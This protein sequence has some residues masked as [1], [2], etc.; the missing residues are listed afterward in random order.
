[1]PKLASLKKAIDKA[2]KIK[3]GQLDRPGVAP[4]AAAAVGGALLLESD[5][6]NGGP[7]TELLKKASKVAKRVVVPLT[8]GTV[9]GLASRSEE[10]RASPFT[11]TTQQRLLTPPPQ[12]IVAD[13]FPQLERLGGF[14]EDINT[15]F[16][17]PL[18]GLGQFI[19]KLGEP[20][21]TEQ[22][23]NGAINA[24]PL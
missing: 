22:R 9:A 12:T 16:G 3:R 4:L 14:I 24:S 21:S 17:Q 19:R 13:E 23:I 10:G 1:M 2:L 5:D 18:Q 20:Q 15:P 11:P 8:A 6:A 7:K